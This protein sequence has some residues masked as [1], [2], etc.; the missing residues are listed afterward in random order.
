MLVKINC[1]FNNHTIKPVNTMTN[2][3][4]KYDRNK[5]RM[6]N[7]QPARWRKKGNYQEGR[8]EFTTPNPLT[9]THT[10]RHTLSFTCTWRLS[11]HLS[12]LIHSLI[13]TNTHTNTTLGSLLL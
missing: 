12:S 4:K 2:Y 1:Q 5:K 7:A 9:H 11:C 10:F 3:T 8:L 13:H 6:K